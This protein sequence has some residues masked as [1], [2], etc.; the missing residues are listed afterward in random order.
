MIQQPLVT[1][2]HWKGQIFKYFVVAILIIS[3]INTVYNLYLSIALSGADAARYAEYNIGN[4]IFLIFFGLI[5]IGHHWY[6]RLMRHIFLLVL[7]IGA[8]FFFDLGA[9][10]RI[11]V[12]MALPII[13]AAFLTRPNYS[14][15]YYGVIAGAYFLRLYLAGVSITDDRIFSFLSLTALL[16]LA[17]VSWLIARSLD[18]A[19]A[20]TRALNTELDQR[21]Q[22]RTR[23]LA[24]ALDRE[25]S[26]AAQ[27][28]T[29]LESI[30]D[31]V[32]VFDAHQQVIVA[33]PAAER[34]TRRSLQTLKLADILASIGDGLAGALL[35]DWISGK[36]PEDRSNIKF[37]LNG[38]TV[39]ANVAPLALAGSGPGAGSVMVWRDFTHE[40]ELE[41]AKDLFLG[42]VSHE[43]RTPL[44]A[45]IGYV[46]VL[47]QVE[48]E[49]LSETGYEY[50]QT[51]YASSRQLLQLANELI[52][53]SRIETGKFSLYQE[54]TDLSSVVLQ[55][56]KTVQQEF[57]RR[58]LYLELKMV[59]NLPDLYID[60]NRM[61]Q[62]LL[63]LLSNAYK[64]T[65]QGGA[66]LEVTQ[67]NGIV[68]VVLA[69]T[70]VGIKPE[71]Q[72]HMFERFFRA[73]DPHIQ[74]AGGTGLGLNIT[75]SLV[76]LHGGNLTFESRHG[77]GTTF[78]MVLPKKPAGVA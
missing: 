21:V 40:A 67:S 60:R 71:D 46:D 14:F 39:L 68:Q 36:K 55:A 52:D 29:I 11:F 53:V 24:E 54:W 59:E 15:A 76:E 16:V 4:Y 63:N 12:A 66:T 42:T 47:L 72:G 35:S 1:E 5:W 30:A 31:G 49:H 33:N 50:L 17:V 19:L 41:R 48:K 10:D 32:V 28:T 57:A 45:M 27:R 18:N 73:N 23:E 43:L 2:D 44:A 56:V 13:M 25:R 20:E 75:R 6:P 58:N 26:I 22:D 38:R 8:I 51:V 77:H 3:A 61:L 74:K 7:V 65:P 78:H 37:D 9:L 64:Y 62:A 70:G 69:D 34:L